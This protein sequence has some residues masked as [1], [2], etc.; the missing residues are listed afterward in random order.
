[1]R[2]EIREFISLIV[3]TFS[4]V[5]P[6]YEFGAFQVRG[7]E[8]FADLRPLFVGKTYVG[9]D[10]REGPGVDV[11]LDLHELDLEPNSVGTALVVE[12]LEHVEF[13]HRAA[14]EVSRVLKAGGCAVFTSLMNFP[15]HRH[16]VDYW[17]F[18]PDG[19]ASILKPFD[20]TFIGAAG[21]SDFPHTVVG[22][23]VKEPGRISPEFVDGFERWKWDWKDLEWPKG[24]NLSSNRIKAVTRLMTPPLITE[25]AWRT[26]RRVKR[27]RSL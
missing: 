12:T 22:I 17:R 23:G 19:F 11:T 27:R 13:P 24:V 8:G 6:V 4:I 16:P 20:E 26:R 2:L 18:T 10:I 5:D 25:L 1:L 3:R 21:Q 15:I 7:Q 14:A 9:S